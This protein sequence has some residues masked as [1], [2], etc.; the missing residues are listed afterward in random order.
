MRRIAI[1]TAMLS[2]L[3]IGP[4]GATPARPRTLRAW[5]AEH[6]DE[7]PHSPAIRARLGERMVRVSCCESRGRTRVVSS[8]GDIGLLQIGRVWHSWAR[9]HG[10]DLFTASGNI[11]VAAHVLDVQGIRAWTPSRGCWG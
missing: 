2:A 4:V 8:T 1:I 6:A 11:A 7:L 5:C 10:H 9:R 3:S